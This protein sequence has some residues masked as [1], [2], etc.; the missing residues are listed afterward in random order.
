MFRKYRLVI[1]TCSKNQIPR[2][3]SNFCPPTYFLLFLI[4]LTITVNSVYHIVVS[5][6]WYREILELLRINN[7][8]RVF[9]KKQFRA[10]Y[11]N[12]DRL[13]NWI[14]LIIDSSVLTINFENW[15]KLDSNGLVFL[16]NQSCIVNRI[17]LFYK[18]N[19]QIS[20]YDYKPAFCFPINIIYF[21]VVLKMTLVQI[22]MKYFKNM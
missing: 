17:L 15:K 8:S 2:Y 18:N 14:W 21:R 20:S 6:Y 11:Q 13:R 9:M 12:F 4:F 5:C 7:V 16:S 1:V 19:H 3:N 10:L 22:D